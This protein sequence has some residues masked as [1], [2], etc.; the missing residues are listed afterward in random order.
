MSIYEIIVAFDSDSVVVVAAA[1]LSTLLS[2]RQWL[3]Q[4]GQDGQII[5]VVVFAPTPSSCKPPSTTPSPP[6]VAH[7]CYNNDVAQPLSILRATNPLHSPPKAYP[8]SQDVVLFDPMHWRL[9]LVFVWS[10]RG[11]FQPAVAM[12]A[13]PKIEVLGISNLQLQLIY[14]FS[15]EYEIV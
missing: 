2:R 9:R 4:G 7:L 14:W 11:K 12:V 3:R 8:L 5:F 15:N 13:I 10:L 1:A 6:H